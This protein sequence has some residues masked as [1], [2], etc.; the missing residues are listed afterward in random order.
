MTTVANHVIMYSK[1]NYLSKIETNPQKD[2]VL[3]A[4]KKT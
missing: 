4:V 1:S 3:S 2:R